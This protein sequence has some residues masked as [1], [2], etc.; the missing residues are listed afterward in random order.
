MS[1]KAIGFPEIP[2]AG[3]WDSYVLVIIWLPLILRILFLLVP[4]RKAI[5]KLAPHTGW[6][7]KQLKSLPIR[8]FGLLALN[9]IL[10]FMIPPILVLLVRFWSDPIGWQQWSEVSNIGGSILLLCLFIWIAMD[11]LRIGRVRRMLVAVEKHDVNKLR[12]VAETGLSVRSW[13]RKF[14]RKKDGDK[15]I[16]DES[17]VKST[18]GK[19]AKSSLKIWGA[20][21]LLARRLTPAGL[22]SSLAYGAAVEVARAGA[23]K[24][25]DLVDKKMQEEFDKLADIN[26]RTLLFLFARDLLMGIIP[27]LILWLLPKV[28]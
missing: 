10:A 4:F 28:V 16:D 19:I 25:S 22:L 18:G 3:P 9:E 5:T 11:M 7:L 24:A 14:G 26:S 21:A 27:I 20:R 15:P 1:T 23:E 13:L 2:P 12:K 8:G 17:I 6:A